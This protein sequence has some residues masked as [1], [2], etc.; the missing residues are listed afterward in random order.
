[1]SDEQKMQIQ[2]LNAALEV[3][4]RTIKDMEKRLAIMQELV[5]RMEHDKRNWEQ[6]RTAQE[7]IIRKQLEFADQEK[8][9]LQ[10]RIVE[11]KKEIRELK[12]AQ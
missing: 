11:L 9:K 12:S 1:M 6:V 10:E 2:R 7:S 8:Q 3:S 4:G 5:T